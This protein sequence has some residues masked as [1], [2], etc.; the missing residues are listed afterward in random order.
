MSARVRLQRIESDPV[1]LHF[2]PGY[3]VRAQ[4]LGTLVTEAHRFLADWLGVEART[5]LSIL[6]Q[7]SW[8]HL[9][10]AP[11][12]YPHS[13]PERATIFAPAHYPPRL[14]SRL[15]AL[16]E[17]A[18]PALQQRLCAEG[19]ALEAQIRTFYDLVAIHE[20]G[21]LF[22]HHLQ[23]A[24]GTRWLTE[25]IANLFATAFFVEARPDL[26]PCWLVWAAIQAEQA[27]PHRTLAAYEAHY[28]VLDFANAN[29]Y[30]GRLNLAAHTLWQRQGRAIAPALVAHF[31]LQA[32]AVAARF[33]QV[34]PSFAW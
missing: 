33:A 25:L 3:G 16:Y 7:E 6:R 34:A 8:R 13:S 27:V 12:G 19:K 30:Q 32:E 24:L 31:S 14:V 4:Q 28:A 11:Y 21:H 26:A 1:T 9:R 10:R 5:T 29:F 17:A 18:P 20:L 15:R 2:S 23:L 22:I